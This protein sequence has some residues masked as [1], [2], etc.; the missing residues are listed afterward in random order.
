MDARNE[1]EYNVDHIPGAILFNEE[2]WD[3]GIERLLDVWIPDQPIVVYCG[4]LDCGTSKRVAELLDQ[5]LGGAEIYSL[6]GGWEAWT[7]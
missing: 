2:D 4:S 7:K 1:D 5:A 3:G 6:Y